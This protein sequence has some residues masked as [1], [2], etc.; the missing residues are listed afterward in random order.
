[1]L[2]QK[3]KF[4]LLILNLVLFSNIS[5]SYTGSSP[6]KKVSLT[7]EGNNFTLN[8][9]FVNGYNFIPRIHTLSTGLKIFL[10]FQKPIINPKI[11]HG[12]K[13]I[14]KGYFFEEFGNSS[15]IFIMALNESV[16]FTKKSY[17]KNSITINFYV[18]QKPTIIIDAGHGGKDP[19]T[20]SFSGRQV[21]KNI[22][23]VTAIEMRNALLRTNRYK[24][25]LTRD[26]DKAVSLDERLAIS[27]EAKGSFLI[28]LHT[29]YNSD[30]SLRGMSI[31]T[32]PDYNVTTFEDQKL[33]KSN[34]SKS[35]LFAKYLTGYVPASCRIKNKTCRN[36]DLKI[37]KNNIPS[38]LIELG[39]ISNELDSKL[40]L[41]KLFREKII[42]AMVYALDKFFGMDKNGK[43]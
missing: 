12:N 35:R 23:L 1:M 42:Y 39:C 2:R 30:K 32:L 24:V 40:L 31:Y 25:V 22:T 6:I 34:L 20:L 9:N 10:S 37:L 3:F 11:E 41:S 21:E 8:I 14:I 7:N 19:G 18:I 17:T 43:R 27:N 26:K 16:I 13:G 4:L 36:G 38:V 15:L 29:D 33:Y 28:S 5:C